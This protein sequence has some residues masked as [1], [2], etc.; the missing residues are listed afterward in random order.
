MTRASVSHSRAYCDSAGLIERSAP[1]NFTI[2]FLFVAAGL[3][4]LVWAIV[5]RGNGVARASGTSLGFCATGDTTRL[6]P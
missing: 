6:S 4:C 1:M 3:F 2:E 5:G